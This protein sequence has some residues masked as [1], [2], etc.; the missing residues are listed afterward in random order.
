MEG[1]LRKVYRSCLPMLC[2][3]RGCREK[4]RRGETKLPRRGNQVPRSLEPRRR[5]RDIVGVRNIRRG[6]EG[7][8]CCVVKLVSKDLF[9]RVNYCEFR[10]SVIT[11][12]LGLR[13]TNRQDQWNQDDETD[14]SRQ[15]TGAVFRL[16]L[17]F[18]LEVVGEPSLE[19]QLGGWNL[20]ITD[21]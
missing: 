10:V 3:I 17:S 8:L 15:N 21:G 5:R 9:G 14:V 11:P 6:R 7:S 18:Q 12:S 2:L 20:D 16:S 19:L 1:R 13:L 4:E